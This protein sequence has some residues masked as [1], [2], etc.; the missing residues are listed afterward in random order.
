MHSHFVVSE[1]EKILIKL[2]YQ[3]LR[4]L[5]SGSFGRVFLV[6]KEDV[7]VL[8]AKVMKL[9]DFDSI[10]Y[11]AGEKLGNNDK[12]PFSLKYKSPIIYERYVVLQMEYANLGNLD[13][14][15]NKN[16]D[17]P[18]PLIRAIMKQILQG[19]LFMHKNKLIH[20]DIKGQNILLH[21][22]LGSGRV[23]LKIA[24]LGIAKAQK[25][26]KY[27]TIMTVAG[28]IPFMSP[29]L[30]LGNDDGA[31]IADN[32]VDIW[33][34]GII[35]HQL[36]AHSFPFKNTNLRAINTFMFSKRLDRPANI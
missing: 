15:I 29:E 25:D 13:K 16:V 4:S 30:L 26:T 10:E 23:I 7:G 2:K 31:I 34:A 9:K 33:S 35:L 11:Q 27:S 17:L 8:A 32:K 24:D 36:V 21:S 14:I 12:N 18:V 3:I 19:L 5:G 6:Y 20:R 1:E 28:T 22:P